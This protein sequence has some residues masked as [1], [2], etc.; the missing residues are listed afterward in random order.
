MTHSGNVLD[1]AI[2]SASCAANTS[3]A[4]SVRHLRRTVPGQPKDSLQPLPSPAG[5]LLDRGCWNHG[6][7]PRGRSTVPTSTPYEPTALP[8]A[9]TCASLRDE[10]SRSA[11]F[12][13][14]T[15]H[16]GRERACSSLQRTVTRRRVSHTSQI[17]RFCTS[18]C[19]T[20][21]QLGGRKCNGHASTLHNGVN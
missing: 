1:M 7:M 19:R 5:I 3:R 16:Y 10:E 17:H 2:R 11:S 14:Y 8:P 21:L 20:Y 9:S 13:S 18:L 6:T 15:L 4:Q 12:M